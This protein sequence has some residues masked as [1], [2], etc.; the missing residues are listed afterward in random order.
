MMLPLKLDGAQLQGYPFEKQKPKKII[1][2]ILI[3]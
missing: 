1:K 2:T 3:Y